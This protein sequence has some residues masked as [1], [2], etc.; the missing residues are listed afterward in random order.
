MICRASLEDVSLRIFSKMRKKRCLLASLFRAFCSF[1]TICRGLM[2][3]KGF[4]LEIFSRPWP[5]RNK[6]LSY[7]SDC[8]LFR[9]LEGGAD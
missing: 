1:G 4:N 6:A 2:W 8:D 5:M 3:E 9:K 7:R